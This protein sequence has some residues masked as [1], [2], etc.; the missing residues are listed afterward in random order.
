MQ[1]YTPWL[2]CFCFLSFPESY[3]FAFQHDFYW[4]SFAS[5]QKWD[6]KG[7]LGLLLELLPALRGTR[8]SMLWSI[9]PGGSLSW[10]VPGN[11]TFLNEGESWLPPSLSLIFELYFEASFLVNFLQDV[12]LK[13]VYLCNT[14]NTYFSPSV[15]LGWK[16]IL[17]VARPSVLNIFI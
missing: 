12:V 8:I 13:I 14:A 6:W 7:A 4:K 1:R 15:I 9:L 3:P 16:K 17:K 5:V 10:E 11:Q 2:F